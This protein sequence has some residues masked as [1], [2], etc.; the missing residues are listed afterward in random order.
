[1]GV[2]GKEQIT[3]MFGGDVLN[4]LDEVT[5]MSY[6]P[7][8]ES[9]AAWGQKFERAT[10]IVSKIEGMLNAF[11]KEE[12]IPRTKTEE[13]KRG[14]SYRDIV[15]EAMTRDMYKG[16]ID[17]VIS[18]MMIGYM[19]AMTGTDLDVSRIVGA[20]ELTQIKGRG[21]G[22][23]MAKAVAQNWTLGEAM[24]ERLVQGFDMDAEKLLDIP[25]VK[26]MFEKLF[27]EEVGIQTTMAKVHP[28]AKKAAL[29]TLF[30]EVQ[31]EF[32]ESML[33]GKGMETVI[34]TATT[35]LIPYGP[36]AQIEPSVVSTMTEE[37]MADIGNVISKEVIEGVSDKL[38]SVIEEESKA[39]TS[40][41]DQLEKRIG[42]GE[43]ITASRNHLP[44]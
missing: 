20:T 26:D 13:G 38:G 28:Q 7:K 17:K 21:S 25:I 24:L 37:T 42:D 10:N 35:P 44:D 9:Q 19:E 31:E 4:F 18:N 36:S 22:R 16:H 14:R 1:M 12:K 43:K 40:K 30:P 11:E 5:A 6:N 15:K 29:A 34:S 23:G 3:E 2:G 33:E 41:W 32:L 8:G 39:E 27:K